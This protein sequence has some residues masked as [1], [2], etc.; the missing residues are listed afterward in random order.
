MERIYDFLFDF[1]RDYPLSCTVF[2]L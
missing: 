2:V 1:N